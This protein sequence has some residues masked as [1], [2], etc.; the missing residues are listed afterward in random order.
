MRIRYKLRSQTNVYI[1]TYLKDAVSKNVL[2]VIAKGIAIDVKA[3]V[4]QEK[5]NMHEKSEEHSR[6]SRER[7]E[8]HCAQ[9]HTHV[10]R[11]ELVPFSSRAA[12]REVSNG[13]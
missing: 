9:E 13:T 7:Q 8:R 12:G 2:V 3:C 1:S 10:E 5:K 4:L 6:R 11:G